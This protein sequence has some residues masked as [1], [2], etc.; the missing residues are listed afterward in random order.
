MRERE[1]ERIRE[2]EREKDRERQRDREGET[3]HHTKV[4][5]NKMQHD[6]SNITCRLIQITRTFKIIMR[7]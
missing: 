6:L 4:K 7:G 2:T 1:R 3:L 5:N